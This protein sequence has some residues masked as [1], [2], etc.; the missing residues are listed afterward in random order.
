MTGQGLPSI[1]RWNGAVELGVLE[2]PSYIGGLVLANERR[3]VAVWTLK[4]LLY[5]I[6]VLY[7]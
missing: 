5:T 2:K 3:L 1:A 6:S 7:F 4:R